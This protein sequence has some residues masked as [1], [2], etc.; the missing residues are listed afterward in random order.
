MEKLLAILTSICTTPCSKDKFISLKLYKAI[1]RHFYNSG[2]HVNVPSTGSL[3]ISD[4]IS[5]FIY[6]TMINKHRLI[7]LSIYEIG[8]RSN[9]PVL[10]AREGVNIKLLNTSVIRLMLTVSLPLIVILLLLHI[11]FFSVTTSL[12][13]YQDFL[14][15]LLC[16][17]M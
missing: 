13:T 5:D 3:E 16:M 1:T 11:F 15:S 4:N 2:N 10:L 14:R 17:L 7:S 8:L 9:C 6:N 12:I